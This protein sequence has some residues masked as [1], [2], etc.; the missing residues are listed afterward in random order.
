MKLTFQIDS[1]K[2]GVRSILAHKLRS[3]LTTLGIIFGV[4]AVISML[5]I[6]DG[7]RKTALEQI[8][9]LGTNNI[10]INH[11]D[12]IGEAKEES[13]SKGSLG[14]TY[15]DSEMIRESIPSL[16]GVAV[17]RFVSEPVFRKNR[18]ATGRVVATT[19][20]YSSVTD[21]HVTEGRF[22]S[23]L[24]VA[25]AKRI[26]VLGA[27]S[28]TELFGYLNPIGR[29]IRIGETWFTVVGVMET[30][31][32]REGRTSV[33]KLRNINKDIYV[34]ITT[35]S[36]RF[37]N[38]DR[39]KGVQ[40]L[41]IQVVNSQQVGIV[42]EIVDR[43][44]KR[45]HHGVE[46]FEIVVPAELLA[47][48]QST[49][50]VF[51]IVMGAIAFISL[52]VGG[53]GIM[54]IMLTTVTERTKEIGVRRAMGATEGAIMEQFLIETVLISMTGGLAGILLGSIMAKS[55]NLFAGWE[56]VIS[57]Y[58]TCLAFGIS[59]LVGIVFGLYPARR[60]AKMNPISALRFE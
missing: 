44:L 45:S 48:A 56:T 32:L 31:E 25:E 3:V 17:S 13:D 55:I 8:R 39:G 26:A 60:A 50:R 33:I 22:I 43:L 20:D 28:R 14:L 54:N 16:A 9:L 23:S 6:A 7:A 53:I 37:P 27:E 12:L 19:S 40:E 52:L 59:G 36:A 35:A 34:P 57:V 18:E 4:G 15:A 41:A 11:L 42:A 10:R 51:N 2:T 1:L 58:S 21:F 5:S 29:R 47:Q 24:D 38:G 49:Q 46:D 30:K